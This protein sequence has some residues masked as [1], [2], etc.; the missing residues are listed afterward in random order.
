MLRT[1]ASGSR[2]RRNSSTA[3]AVDLSLTPKNDH[4]RC[5]GGS[6]WTASG[7][8][9][10]A[11]ARER[12]STACTPFTGSLPASPRLLRLSSSRQSDLPS[13][14]K[15]VTK[16]GR[17]LTGPKGAFPW[18][19]DAT[20]E[21]LPIQPR[22][23]RRSGAASRSSNLRNG[24]H[25]TRVASTTGQFTDAEPSQSLGNDHQQCAGNPS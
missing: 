24:L 6:S 7:L 1:T 25:R 8:T 20:R 10:L 2:T 13:G 14:R 5:P 15:A 18:N 19:R 11:H 16:S 12:S 21:P 4:Q 23:R 9:G 3:T 22:S 17:L